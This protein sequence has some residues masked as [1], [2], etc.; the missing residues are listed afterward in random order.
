MTII[1]GKIKNAI[2]FALNGSFSLYKGKVICT[3]E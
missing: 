2:T 1:I 3:F